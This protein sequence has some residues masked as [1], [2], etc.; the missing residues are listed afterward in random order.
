[1]WQ[2]RLELMAAPREFGASTRGSAVRMYHKHLV[3]AQGSKAAAR[4]H[5]GFPRGVN[6]ATL[7]NWIEVG[8]AA[9]SPKWPTESARLALVSDADCGVGQR[10]G[11]AKCLLSFAGA[12]ALTHSQAHP[13]PEVGPPDLLNRP[14]DRIPHD[15]TLASPA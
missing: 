7:R 6:P 13:R 10:V 14:E 3:D 9:F 2:G 12:V 11:F 5:V 1:M 8:P 15:L 4:T